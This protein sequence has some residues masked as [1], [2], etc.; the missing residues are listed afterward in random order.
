MSKITERNNAILKSR[1]ILNNKD[2]YIIV[3]TETS[4]IGNHAEVL[5]ICAI[6]LNG[7]VLIESFFKPKGT[8]APEAIAVHGLTR[9]IL[10]QKGAVTWNVCASEIAQFF[11]GKTILAYNASFDKKMIDQTAAL[12]GYSSPI[13]ETVCVMRLRQQFAGTQNTEKL[14]GDHTAQGDCRKTL[15][16]LNE[17]AEAELME[18]PESFDIENDD[19]LINLCFKLQEISEQRLAL[20]KQEKAIQARCGLYL[21]EMEK[22]NVPLGN[23]KKVERVQSIVELKPQ[24]SLEELPDDY[25]VTRLNHSLVKKLL[26]QGKVNNE[27]FSYEEKWSIK[28]KKQ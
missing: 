9:E 23:G 20:E 18:D 13:K 28:I 16:L 24:I 25:K 26:L 4:G 22:E 3:D 21:K 15:E 7:E 14:Q 27:L 17:I 10:Q 1:E 6:S 11:S 5:E 8:I 12:Y 2:N 19:D